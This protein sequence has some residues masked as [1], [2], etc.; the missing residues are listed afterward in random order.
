LTLRELV[1]M[2]DARQREAWG[3]LSTLLATLANVNRDPR[4]KAL[5]PDDFN[6]YV[7]K[8]LSSGTPITAENV[9][10]LKAWVNRGGK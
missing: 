6:P 5:S 10:L 3:R 8:R 2:A 7:E 9:H 1:L 4:K